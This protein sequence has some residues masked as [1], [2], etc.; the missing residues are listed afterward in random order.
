MKSKSCSFPHKFGLWVVGLCCIF[1]GAEA[2]CQNRYRIDQGIEIR[3]T[4]SLP[5]GD[6]CFDVSDYIGVPPRD[7]DYSLIGLCA[8]PALSGSVG[9]YV[10]KRLGAHI[11]LGSGFD[12]ALRRERYERSA[13]PSVTNTVVQ[14]NIN[15]FRLEVPLYMLWLNDSWSIGFGGKVLIAQAYVDVREREDGERFR[16]D[17]DGLEIAGFDFQYSF[18]GTL[19]VLELERN[20]SI[21]IVSTCDHRDK[22]NSQARRGWIDV[23]I[24]AAMVW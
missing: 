9:W 8:K 21:H 14:W 13:S 15:R 11:G 16:S 4:L 20:R 18:R 6:R 5:Y 17:S 1:V 22:W 2:Q 3:T 7:I 19:R 23:S 12:I 10:A 24:G